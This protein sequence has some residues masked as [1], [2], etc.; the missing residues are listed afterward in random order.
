MIPSPP[1]TPCTPS[2]TLPGCP[3][4]FLHLEFRKENKTEN[5]EPTPLPKKCPHAIKDF[6]KAYASPLHLL[7]TAS[8]WSPSLSLS[9]FQA[10]GRA[11]AC[12]AGQMTTLPAFAV[13]GV[14]QTGLRFHLL[15][16]IS[17]VPPPVPTLLH[18]FCLHDVFTVS[19]CSFPFFRSSPPLTP[20]SIS[21]D[22]T[23]GIQNG[24]R[25]PMSSITLQ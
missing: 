5:V 7:L 13:G 23:L 19:P 10:L 2:L 17:L 25:L 8:L 16:P 9:S 24:L 18:T 14:T 11:P 21:V 12:S 15:Y 1:S 4:C 3:L 22:L 6:G 20:S